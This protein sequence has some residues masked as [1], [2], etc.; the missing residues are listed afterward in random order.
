MADMLAS[1]EDLASVLKR[2]FDI[3]DTA[4]AVLALEAATAVVQ[5]AAGQLIVR[6]TTTETAWGGSDRV[7]RLK[8]RPVVSVASVTYGG[9]L[10]SQGTASGTWRLAADGLW[11][12]IGWT[13]YVSEPSPVEVVYTYGY[14][15]TDQA[16]Q[17]ARGVTL[18]IARGLFT[19][20]DG[21]SR[22]SIDDYS[23]QYEHAAA[24]LDATPHTKA[25]L[26]RMYG[27]KAAMVRIV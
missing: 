3:Y 10:L 17:L 8:Q 6:G 24:A 9:S 13:E 19:N 1:A 5:A 26:R 2:S 4:T 22:E 15:V 18:S 12:D 20:P 25:A 16:I 27:S 11:R 21:V 23:V 7:L 14:E